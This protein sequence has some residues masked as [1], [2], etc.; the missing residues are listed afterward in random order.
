MT[1]ALD[2]A[3]AVRQSGVKLTPL[4]AE[5]ATECWSFLEPFVALAL[6]YSQ[7]RLE[8]EDVKRLVAEGGA[9]VLL[10]WKP[11]EKRVHAV[12]LCEGKNYAR[13]KVFSIGICGG[14]D[15]FEWAPVVWPGILHIARDLGYDQVE[16]V[17]RRGW[18]RFLAGAREIATLYA[19]D[20]KTEQPDG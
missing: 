15:L 3:L 2:Q 8:L 9:L 20:L 13:K 10:A 11:D 7:E 12:M 17:G 4:T 5:Y 16:V 1:A 14:T 18:G 19:I 6:E